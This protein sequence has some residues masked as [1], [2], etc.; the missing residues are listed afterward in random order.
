LLAATWTS[1]ANSPPIGLGTMDLLTNG[2][3]LM[4]DGGNQWAILTPSSS[5]SYINGTWKRISNANYTRLYDATQVLQNGNLFIAGG[6]YGNG[7]ATGEIYNTLTNTWTSLPSQSFGS[8]IDSESMLLPNG[9]VLIAPVAPNPSGYTT[10]FNTATNTWSQGPKLFRGGS[11]DEQSFVKLPDGSILT[12]DGG[13]TSERYIPSSNSW[14]N[15]GA[16]P[17]NLFDGL[18][19]LGPGLLLNDGRAIFFGATSTSVIYTPSGTS[20]PGTWTSGPAIPNSLGCDDAPGAVLRDGTILLATGPTGTYNGPTTFYIYDPVANSFSLAPGAPTISSAPYTE[21]ML[22]LPDGTVM[23]EAGGQLRVFDPGTTATAASVPTITSLANNADGSILLTGTNLNGLDAGAAYGDDAQMDTNYPIVRLVNGSNV[24]YAR[25]YNWSDTGVA[26]GGTSETVDFTL[27]LGIPAGTY[28]AYAVANGVPSAPMSLAISTTSN[29]AAPTV[30]TPAAVSASPVTGTTVNLSVLGADDGGESNLTYTWSLSASS[31]STQLPSISDNGDNTA[32]NMTATFHQ[33]GTYTF[34]VTI[35]DTG[36]L[37]TTS[38]VN[39][40]VN[41]TYSGVNVTPALASVGGS[42]TQQFSASAYDQFGNALSSQPGFTWHVTAGTGSISGGGLYSATASGTLAT[43][44]ASATVSGTTFT[45]TAQ[46]GV[47]ASPWNSTDIGSPGQTGTAYDNGTTFTVE[48]G[49]GDIWGTSDQFHFVYQTLTGDGVMIARVASYT[50]TGGWAKVG[51]MLRNSLNNNDQYVLECI[52]P[53]NGSAFQYRTTSGGSAAATGGTGGLVAPYYVKLVRSGTTVTGYRSTDGNTWTLDGSLSITFTNSTIYA[54]LEVDANNNSLLN[55]STFDHVALLPGGNSA[56]TVAQAAKSA[57]NPVTGTSAAL[58][59]LGADANPESFLTYTWAATTVPSGVA[60]PTFSANTSNAAK[61]T[62]ATVSAAGNYVF[63]VTITNEYGLTVTSSVSV[64]VSQTASGSLVVL[65]GGPALLLSQTCQMQVF[66]SDQFGAAMGSPLSATWSVSPTSGAGTI[67]STGLYTAPASNTT[68]TITATTSGGAANTTV[69]VVQPNDYWKFN[70]T[71]GST[72]ADSGSGGHTGTLV[73]SPTWTTSGVIGGALTFNG[74]SQ[75][76]SASSLNLNSN[77]V[78]ISAWVYRTANESNT[79]GIVF[80][81]SSSTGA[82]GLSFG[83]AN[84]LRYNWNNASATWNWNSGLVVPTSQWTFVA[85]VITASNAT[86][87]MEPLGGA[88]QSATNAVANSASTFDGTSYIGQDTLN[89]NRFFGGT[90][91]DVRVYSTSLSATALASIANAGPTVAT[92]AAASPS[93][94]TGTTTNLS[95]LGAENNGGGESS[96]TYTWSTTGSPPAAVSYSVNGTNAAKNTTATFTKTGTYSFLVTITDPNG[97]SATSA[98]SVTV[99][100]T[101]TSVV[102]NPT[103]ASLNSGGS[104]QFAA[105]VYDQ[106]GAVM[107]VHPTTTWAVASGGGSVSSVGLYTAPYASGT[108]TVTATSGSATSSPTTVTITDAAPTVAT[109]AAASPS[110]VT[111]MTTNLSVLGADSDGGGEFNLTYTWS[112]TGT[113]PAAVSYS[114]NGTHAAKNTTATFSAAGAYSFLVTITDLGGQSTTSSVSVTVNQTLSSIAVTPSI[115]ALASGATQQFAATAYDQFGAALSTQPTFTWAV[116]SGVGGI[117]SSSGL[118]TASYASGSATIT[119]ASGNVTSGPAAVTIADA[120]PTVATA[121]AALPSPV[122]G[123]TTNLSVLG[124][125]SDG[126]GEPNLSYTWSTT[127]TPP[128]AVSFSASGTNAAKNTTA[129]FSAAGIY[130]FLVT[131]TDLGGQSTTSAVS[132]TVNQT[133]TS[134]AVSPSPAAIGSGA[135]E[136]FSATANDQ[137]GAAM[138]TQPTFTWAVA[139]GVGSIDS[140]SGLYTAPFASGAATVTATSGDVSSSPAAVTVTD[141]APTVATAAAAS[142]VTGTTTN[143]SVLGADSDGGGESNLTY[144][145]STTGTP[146]AAVSFSVNGTNAAKNT[147]ATLSAAGTYNFLVTITDLGG[148]STTSAVNVTVN[149]TFTS[150]AVSPSMIALGSGATQ[151]FTATA[152]DQFGAAMTTQPT[153]TWAVASGVGNIDSSSGLYTAPYASGAAT[154]TATSGNVTSSPAAVTVTDAVPTV[155]TASAASPVTG[156]TTNLSVLGADSDG[157]GESNL[158]YTWSTT[159][160]PPAAVSFSANGTNAAKN[161]TATFAQAGDYNFLVTITDL[162]GQSTTSAVSVTVSQTLMGI[163]VS[164]STANITAGSTQQFTVTGQDQFGKPIANPSVSWSLTGPGSLSSGGLYTPAYAPGTATVQATSGSL[165]NTASAMVTGQA[166]WDSATDASWGAGGSWADSVSGTTIAAPGVRG[167]AGDTVLFTTVTGGT[168]ALD[169]ATP[170][171]AGI[172]F[173]NATTS[174]TIAPGS[175]GSVTLQ[176]ASG[177]TVS[178]VSGN[179]SITAPLVLASATTFSSAASAKLTIGGNISG[180]GGFTKSGSGV[181]ELSGGNTYGGGTVVAAGKLIVNNA[182]ALPDGGSLTVGNASL[183]A[184]PPAQAALAAPTSQSATIVSPTASIAPPPSLATPFS[185]VAARATI[186]GQAATTTSPARAAAAWF[187]RLA[188][189]A[190][191]VSDAEAS[192]P[193]Q[194]A[195]LRDIFFLSYGRC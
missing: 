175:G 83:T 133:F 102:V 42:K 33:A 45:G 188:A 116:A 12:I 135:T 152:D 177:A 142:P 30:A 8:F 149:Q 52:T 81:R 153:F 89:G 21:R 100:R 53:S 19:E 161:T 77:T 92:A 158:T 11:T 48:G 136:Q 120:A 180:V 49:G 85:L 128:A 62:T 18:G 187:S 171:L 145:W 118:Y 38:S 103:S 54:G 191:G 6:E 10:I 134:V 51:V 112:T 174:Y 122:T 28:S 94:V 189:L 193:D 121:A 144:T 87:Y 107:V 119:A 79:A 160:T 140:S 123:T 154:V 50:N 74:T 31:N 44:T 58:S 56:P 14:V 132:V 139:S 108:A 105:S 169:G 41:Q 36:G 2:S 113:P 163:A 5:G 63:Q 9:N 130:N 146:P 46:A 143:L 156:T 138:T 172:A 114:A 61:N 76:V 147:T 157:G 4:T 181:V 80:D 148:Q 166:R 190:G 179:H 57:T 185:A 95:V 159:G 131:I 26:L 98:V 59:V 176:S 78:T 117:D 97:Q 40:T 173:D 7:A 43:V 20:S 68:A 82:S 168:A 186:L 16:V 178:V 84:E 184:S 109:A 125:D 170:A 127:G 60:M 37:S 194:N 155:A 70:E 69:Q 141:A 111:G 1:L 151:Q 73:G 90:L 67:S 182:S 17:Q 165:N 22:A 164:P 24:Y 126:G 25:T 32:K 66:N 150:V 47:V 124:A 106:F 29:N 101:A 167:I 93:P 129:T 162:G 104:Q 55:T 91:D 86:M 96:L 115:A 64:T 3:V 192:G 34:K 35:T 75:S 39:V 99:S 88:M 15:D 23:L 195:R 72:A 13:S 137:F 183:F 27:P 110:P 71:S 65:P